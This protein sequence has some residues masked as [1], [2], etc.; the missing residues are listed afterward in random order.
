MARY[1]RISFNFGWNASLLGKNLVFGTDR[2]APYMS[3]VHGMQYAL[4]IHLYDFAGQIPFPA[5]AIVE[6][7][8]GNA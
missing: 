8:G 4:R 2:F 1:D 7:A 3:L 6:K 5:R